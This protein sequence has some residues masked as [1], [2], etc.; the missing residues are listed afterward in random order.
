[1][2]VGMLMAM[3]AFLLEGVAGLEVTETGGEA[4]G[5]LRPP[6]PLAYPR[7][8]LLPH[9]NKEFSRKLRTVHSSSSLWARPL[10]ALYRLLFLL[11]FHLLRVRPS[12]PSVC[13]RSS[14]R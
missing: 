13:P 2:G 4:D 5:F 10:P 3:A 14:L 6:W 1:M 8:F 7:P 11:L 9:E 12:R